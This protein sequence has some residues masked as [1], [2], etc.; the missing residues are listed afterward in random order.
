MSGSD[1]SRKVR[2]AGKTSRMS[3]RGPSGIEGHL[4]A[5]GGFSH[6]HV[7]GVAVIFFRH[8]GGVLILDRS[9]WF[10]TRDI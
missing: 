5:G 1:K 3:A 4:I 2:V 7:R 9:S 8:I 10:G 6:H